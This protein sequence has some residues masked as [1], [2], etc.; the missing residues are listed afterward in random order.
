MILIDHIRKVDDV[1]H[2]YYF[3]K[4]KIRFKTFEGGNESY[5]IHV[6]KIKSAIVIAL[7]ED[8]RNTIN[9]HFPA[10]NTLHSISEARNNISRYITWSL[11]NEH[12]TEKILKYGQKVIPLAETI[13]REIPENNDI[14]KELIFYIRCVTFNLNHRITI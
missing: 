10:E 4:G 1:F 9:K 13:V 6:E 11:E 12:L 8:F 2:Y 7:F 3:L 5:L 14:K